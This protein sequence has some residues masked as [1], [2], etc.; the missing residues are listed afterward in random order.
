M[1]AKPRTAERGRRD[2]KRGA[3]VN[4]RAGDGKAGEQRAG[5]LRG[6]T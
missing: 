6:R 2:M 1:Q 5:A 3:A 4:G